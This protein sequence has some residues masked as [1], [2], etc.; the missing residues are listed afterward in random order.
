MKYRIKGSKDDTQKRNFGN[1]NVQEAYIVTPINWA[2]SFSMGISSYNKQITLS[3][4]FCEDSYEME[5]VESFLDL[6]MKE[7]PK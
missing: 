7:L 4:G 3:I 5:S 2:P 6:L 1:V